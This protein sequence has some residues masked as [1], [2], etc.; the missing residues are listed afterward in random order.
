MENILDKKEMDSLDSLNNRYKKL[1]DPGHLA[2]IGERA[3][4]IVP[5]EIKTLLNGVGNSISEQELYIQAMEQISNGF[6]IIEEQAAKLSVSK[7]KIVQ[8]LQKYEKLDSYQDIP[9]LRCYSISKCVDN[10]RTINLFTA[11]LEG[12]GTGFF[13]FA[14]LPFNLVLSIFIY[15]RAVQSIAMYYGYDVKNDNEELIIANSVFINALSPSKSDTN[16]EL[17]AVITKVMLMSKATIIKETSKKTWSDMAA[18]G[19]IPLLLTQLRA[20]SHKSA[21]KALE[22]TGQKGLETKLFKDTFELIGKKLTQK[23]INKS[24]P[25]VSAGIGAFLDTAQM[26]RVLEYADIFYQKRFIAE[27]ESRILLLKEWEE[28]SIIEAEFID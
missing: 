3:I 7:Q 6:R 15:F 23:M 17:S 25:F 24:I 26:K 9:K 22:K 4:K 27:K 5:S 18:R 11:F 20:L 14:G 16:N 8:N 13:G 28:N 1:T 19:G 10:F 2:K 21:A 12:G